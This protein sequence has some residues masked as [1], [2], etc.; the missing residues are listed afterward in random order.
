MA[1]KQP[2][3][4][5]VRVTIECL[6]AVLGGVQSL[7]TTSRDEALS[8]PTEESATL[9]LRTQQIVAWES[10]AA[11]VIDPLGGSYYVEALTDAIE[12]EV[13]K[14]IQRIEAQG[15]MRR[16]VETGWVQRQLADEGYRRQKQLEDGQ[17]TIIGVNKYVTSE[18]MAIKLH[19]PNPKVAEAMKA[20][21]QKLRQERN[22]SAVD[23]AL[24]RIRKAAEGNENLLPL[25]IDAV[26]K[27]A[28]IGEIAG[29]LRAAFGEY[30]PAFAD[31][32]Y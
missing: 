30:R 4:N 17:R 26:S 16:A 20:R 5:V 10:G 23:E 11:Q 25:F 27:L 28:T 9:A 14:Y 6:A 31:G 2:E 29:A 22:S 3:N 1:A 8:I 24:L 13:T 32:H 15:G 18:A 12:E 19:R 21:L 7:H